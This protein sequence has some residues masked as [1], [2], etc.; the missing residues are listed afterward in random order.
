M[1]NTVPDW[2]VGID[3]VGRGPIAGPV[4]VCAV[5]LPY[6]YYTQ[7][8]KE[9]S[10]WRVNAVELRD[11]KKMTARARMQWNDARPLLLE[12]GMR[13]AIALRSAHDID[14][15]GIALCISECI[16]DVLTHL[17]IDPL[18][19]Y[20]LLDGAL[21]APSLYRQQTVIKGDVLHPII[22]LASVFAKVHRDV[23]MNTEHVHHPQY[24]WNTNKGYGTKAHYDA[25]MLYGSTPLHRKSFMK[26][27]LRTRE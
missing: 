12:K 11:S 5:A 18:S 24:G 15:K 4:C 7:R 16:E 14:K 10:V 27:V 13:S 9:E 3:E 25:V 21:R 6:A 1:D 20:V 26:E 23:L 8:C 19:C 2:I 17:A 22:S